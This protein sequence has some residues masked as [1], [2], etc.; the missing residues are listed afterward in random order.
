MVTLTKTKN[1]VEKSTLLLLVIQVS[2]YVKLLLDFC[3][4]T[5]FCLHSLYSQQWNSTS[6]PNGGEVKR[7]VVNPINKNIIY[8]VTTTPFSGVLKSTNRGE[9]W[10][11]LTN[12]LQFD[13]IDSGVRMPEELAIDVTKPETLY[14][15]VNHP[16]LSDLSNLYRTT[17]GGKTWHIV[18][19]KKI[20]A[21]CAKNGFVFA[22]H[23][24]GLLYSSNAGDSWKVRN[25][26]LLGN[27]ILWDE[28][29][30][31]WIGG[32]QG[33]FRSN[34]SGKTYTLFTF[35]YLWKINDFD[36][37]I[38]DN[39]KLVVVS[40]AGISARYDSVYISYDEGITWIN[41]TKTLPYK[42]STF[43]YQIPNTVKI[44]R[45]N[46]NYIFAGS[47]V[48]FYRTTNAGLQWIKQD[49]GL[50]LPHAL[51]NNYQTAVSSLEIFK[52]DSTLIFA[53]T[54]N[55]GIYRSSDG[56][57]TWQLL[58]MPSG[59]VS[60]IAVA[61]TNNPEKIYC[62]ASGGLYYFNDNRWFPTTMLVGQIIA[63]NGTTALAVSPHNSNLILVGIQ[64]SIGHALLYRTTDE[65]TS[66]SL[67]YLIPIGRARF[68]K[69]IFATNDSNRVYACWD[70]GLLISDDAGETWQQFYSTNVVDMAIDSYNEKLFLLGKWGE[71]NISTDRGITWRTIRSSNDSEHTVIKI[72]PTNS[73]RI[74]VGSFNLWVS[75]DDGTSWERKPFDKKV[76]DI[77]FDPETGVVYVATLKQGVWCSFDGG[78]NFTKMDPLPSERI[79]KLLFCVKNKKKLIVGTSG[80]G[81]Y[82]YD[83]GSISSVSGNEVVP[84]TVT[85]YQN[86][87]NPFNSATVIKYYLTKSSFVSLKIYDIL[88]REIKTLVENWQSSGNY[89]VQ[90]NV[91]N[92]LNS[93]IYF[94]VLNTASNTAVKKIML[95]R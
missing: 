24:S 45:H 26:S 70:G 94:C 7:I 88:G 20:Y 67:R 13:E 57:V 53:G 71:I 76:M 34:D 22:L 48:G 62:G 41:R 35:P 17:N 9:T 31:L 75:R 73:Q 82:E 36:V 92:D 84:Q 74:Y 79:T 63:W 8:A 47:S 3:L 72:D 69:F 4:M 65:G 50:T 2:Y 28:Q 40:A 64:N 27:K 37:A 32:N 59:V 44:S 54:T 1:F 86:Y 83:L 93:G 29:N 58:S 33:L 56:G 77:A 91:P 68:T 78:N 38:G 87:P 15:A 30:V 89:T 85:F 43:S 12:G 95:L 19:A 66:W 16:Q 60:T 81:V 10:E 25:H 55:D 49:S 5:I 6:G 42:P 46:I 80:V 18:L 11:A 23:D 61:S 51:S 39:Q 14:V 90:W 21:I 52:N